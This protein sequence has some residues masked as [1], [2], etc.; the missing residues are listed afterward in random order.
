MVTIHP[1]VL[2]LYLAA[3][4]DTVL[5]DFSS[6][7]C[8][9]CRMMQPIVRRLVEEGYPVHEIDVDRDHETAA[10]FGVTGVPCFVMLRDGHEVDRVVGAASHSRL[11]QMFATAQYPAAATGRRIP[12]AEFAPGQSP[13]DDR[14]GQNAPVSA[15]GDRTPESTPDQVSLSGDPQEIRRRAFQATVRLKVEDANGH[16][17]GSGTIVD[18]HGAEALVLTCGH[19]FRESQGKGRITADFFADGGEHSTA[20]NLISFDPDRDIGLVS[21]VPN[22]SVEPVPVASATAPIRIGKAVFSVG[23]DRGGSPKLLNSQI[24][25]IDKYVGPPNIEVLGQPV[26]GRSGGGL[27]AADT[28]QLIGVCNM[29]DPA[30]NEGIYAALATIHWEL[31]RVGLRQIYQP[32]QSELAGNPRP[33]GTNA[34]PPPMPNSMPQ[35]V[36]NTVPVVLPVPGGPLGGSAPESVAAP[37]VDKSEIICI[38]R[39]NGQERLVVLEHPSPDLVHMLAQESRMAEIPDEIA[40]LPRQGSQSPAAWPNRRKNLGHPSADDRVRAQSADQ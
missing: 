33:T 28:G 27:F 35:N 30:D 10:R 18:V 12:D 9:P 20:G 15:P 16:S 8:G 19:I 17:V 1:L 29:A 31:D 6:E 38:I 25:A 36:P 26:D 13:G 7:R 24:T 3:A 32:D 2:S 14:F 21:I 4:G 22:V 39:R 37:S 23:C 34:A 40:L 5:L 11:L